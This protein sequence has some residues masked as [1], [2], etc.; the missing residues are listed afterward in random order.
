MTFFVTPTNTS[1]VPSLSSG[2]IESVSAAM[3]G[4][5][6]QVAIR[7]VVDDMDEEVD[8]LAQGLGDKDWYDARA[9]V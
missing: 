4:I 5:E 6:E 2:R 7:K 9:Y 8:T 3:P 1:G